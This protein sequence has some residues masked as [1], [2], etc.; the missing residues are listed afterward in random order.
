MF[1]TRLSSTLPFVQKYKREKKNHCSFCR[2][3]ALFQCLPLCLSWLYLS[4]WYLTDFICIFRTLH[5]CS[6]FGLKCSG[7]VSRSLFLLLSLS[8]LHE[9]QFYVY[10]SS[11]ISCDIKT[12]LGF[13]HIPYD[14]LF[15]LI[16]FLLILYFDSCCC[17]CCCCY[18]YWRCCFAFVRFGTPKVE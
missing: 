8:V 9:M 6:V 15:R 17:C 16:C 1:C 7:W 3:R 13:V 10:L 2:V 4:V 5:L 18:C 12:E 11:F 14:F